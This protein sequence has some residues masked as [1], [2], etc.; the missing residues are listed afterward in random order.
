MRLARTSGVL[1]VGLALALVT[2]VPASAKIAR[3]AA[4]T[5]SGTHGYRITFRATGRGAALFVAKARDKQALLPKDA[6]ARAAARQGVN[7]VSI[8]V[9]KH[10]GASSYEDDSV[11]A[12]FTP[13]GFSG[14]I[15]KLGTVDVVF[16][17]RARHRIPLPPGACSGYLERRTG[18]FTGRISFH[19]STATRSS[20]PGARRGTSTSHTTSAV[21]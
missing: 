16:H 14:S 20:T 1:A 15:G 13:A 11:T 6:A 4:F 5:L 9:A 10:G 8:D 18:T 3:S 7:H 17:G 21:A 2:A 19:G 12:R